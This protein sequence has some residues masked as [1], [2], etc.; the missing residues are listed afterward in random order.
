M[1]ASARNKIQLVLILLMVIAA[2]RVGWIYYERRQEAATPA[3]KEAPPLNPDYYVTPKKVYAYDL[4]TAKQELTRQPAWVKVGYYCSYY[5]YDSA[6]RHADLG[7]DS[8]K[9][10]PLETS[11]IAMRCCFSKTRTDCTSTGRLTSGR[12]LISMR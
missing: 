3:K 5:P 2:V 4:K 8:G 12:R 11:S 10:L 6:A 9:L 7:H 1:E